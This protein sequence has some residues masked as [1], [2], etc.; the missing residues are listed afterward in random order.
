MTIQ[1]K[2][3]IQRDFA[4]ER[5]N[6]HKSYD[7]ELQY[8]AIFEQSPYGILIIDTNGAFVDFNAEAHRQLGYSR[9]EFAKLRISDIDPLQSPEEIEA[10]MNEVLGKGKAEFDVTH[11]TKDGQVRYVHVIAQALH[12]D[13]R[14]VFQT[15]W[16][17]ITESKLAEKELNTYR[18][19]LEKVIGE[20][21]IEL[22]RANKRLHLDLAERKR[23]EAEKEKLVMELQRALSE[24][25]ALRGLLPVCA[26]CRKIR[27]D[28]GYWHKIEQYIESHSDAKFTHGI[29]PQCIEEMQKKNIEKQEEKDQEAKDDEEHFEWR[30]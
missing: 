23:M 14:T 13:G 24:I 20:R 1:N 2:K 17:D 30:I 4:D 28:N 15:I 8:Q 27:D 7:A 3:D 9:E 19:H 11:R 10:S 5:D 26:W 25:K 16:Q 12:L 6:A 29:C 18:N 21:T 22:L